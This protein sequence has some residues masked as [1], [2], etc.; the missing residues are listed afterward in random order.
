MIRLPRVARPF[1]LFVWIACW[2]SV[3]TAIAQHEF[4]VAY[5]NVENLFDTDNDPTTEDDAFLPTGPYQWNAERYAKKLGNLARVIRALGNE[6][7]TAAP[8]GLLGLCEV[9]NARVVTDLLDSAGLG[10]T[11]KVILIDSRYYRGV[12]VALVYDTRLFRVVRAQPFAVVPDPAKPRVY[13][14]DILW[15]DLAPASATGGPVFSVLVNHWPSR[16]SSDEARFQAAAVARRALDSVWS[17]DPARPVVMMGDFNDEPHSPSIRERLGTS[18]D[19]LS[20]QRGHTPLLWDAL[21]RYTEA[22]LGTHRFQGKWHLLDHFLISSHLIGGAASAQALVQYVPGSA[23]VFQP[24]FLKETD[25]RYAGNPFRTFVGRDDNPRYLGGFADH[26]PI[27]MRLRVL[28][29]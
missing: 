21:A 6:G 18:P 25:P 24:D 3:E 16:G 2:L 8:V 9:E 20:L 27:R 29:P 28:N 12:D 10:S 22:R 7:L 15:V 11:H 23:G 13:S 5:Y 14:R 4:T 26:F 19:S 17:Q 1:G